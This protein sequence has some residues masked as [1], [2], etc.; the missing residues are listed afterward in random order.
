MRLLVLPGDGIGPENHQGHERWMPR[1]PIRRPEPA[2]WA[3]PPATD[4]F[5]ARVATAIAG[6]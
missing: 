4:A 5:A 1:W 6:K 3:G 2:I